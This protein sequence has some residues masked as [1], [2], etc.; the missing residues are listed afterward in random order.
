MA[1]TSCQT[2]NNLPF[3]SRLYQE[4]PTY[5]MQSV[6][7]VLVA[8]GLYISENITSEW[9]KT[10]PAPYQSVMAGQHC[11]IGWEITGLFVAFWSIF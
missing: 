8:C 1:I 11:H 10:L 4:L 2:K 9:Q 6:E 5:H 3:V 7:Y